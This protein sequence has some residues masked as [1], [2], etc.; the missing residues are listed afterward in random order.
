MYAVI[1]HTLLG[2]AETEFSKAVDAV[3]AKLKPKQMTAAEL[4]QVMK[5]IAR[6]KGRGVSPFMFEEMLPPG[7]AWSLYSTPGLN[8]F[9]LTAEDAPV[10]RLYG[11][12][13]YTWVTD[14]RLDVFAARKARAGW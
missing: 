7:V 10:V 6:A 14:G 11:E 8:V 2:T 12:Y 5:G 9:S 4:G 13:F 1:K 3:N